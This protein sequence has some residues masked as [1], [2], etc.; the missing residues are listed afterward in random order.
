MYG[1]GSGISGDGPQYLKNTEGG[2][3]YQVGNHTKS[4]F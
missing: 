2:A 4:H 1:P 3:K